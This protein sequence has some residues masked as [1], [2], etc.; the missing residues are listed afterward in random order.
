RR[1]SPSLHDALS[2]R[3]VG[4]D[5][6][7]APGGGLEGPGDRRRLVVSRFEDDRTRLRRA[8]EALVLAAADE[9]DLRL[10][11]E[12]GL[13]PVET[14]DVRRVGDDDG[15][16]LGRRLR[17][18]LLA[19]LDLETEP[20]G[21][22]AGEREGVRRDVYADD[23]RVRPLVLQRE[24]DRARADADVE[25]PRPLDPVD[26]SEDTLDERLRLRPRHERARVGLQREP[27]EAPLAE[28]VGE[29]LAS[30]AAGEER[31]ESL[32]L[33]V[34]AGRE[35]G[36]RRPEHVGDEPLR[37]DPGR[38]DA[39]RGEPALGLG[40]SLPRRHSPSARRCSSVESASVNSSSSPPRIRSSWWSVSR[41]SGKLYVR[42]FSARSPPPIWERRSAS[43]S[44]RCR[45]SSRS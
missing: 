42:I 5:A 39:G 36:A 10:P 19:K 30:L 31:L 17:P 40:E 12:L 45:S 20:G 4:S 7:V 2:S 37:V 43:S 35:T 44:A 27:A 11:A 23:V 29:R 9:R 33:L 32:H 25:D 18:V 26:E 13:E 1:S 16:A 41:F 28:D 21:V 24:R 22:L 38:L 15:P 34:R 6:D 14:R 8:G 3:Q